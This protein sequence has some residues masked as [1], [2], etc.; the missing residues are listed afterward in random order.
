LRSTHAHGICPAL[1]IDG[2]AIS[3]FRMRAKE[4][5]KQA[6]SSIS[7]TRIEFTKVFRLNTRLL[8]KPNRLRAGAIDP[9]ELARVHPGRFVPDELRADGEVTRVG[10]KV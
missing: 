4:R 9:V 3:G 2:G 6:T 5:A 8:Q 10:A 1:E 7:R